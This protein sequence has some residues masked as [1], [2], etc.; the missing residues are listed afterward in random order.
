[1]TSL[2]CTLTRA[3]MIAALYQ[4]SAAAAMAAQALMPLVVDRS[5][6]VASLNSAQVRKRRRA[7]NSVGSLLPVGS[8]SAERLYLMTAAGWVAFALC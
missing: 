2:V 4:Y 6:K 7:R 3:G 5:T 8:D 1:M